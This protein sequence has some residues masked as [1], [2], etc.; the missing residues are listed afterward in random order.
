M[1]LGDF[2]HC[3]FHLGLHL[4]GWEEA[5]ATGSRYVQVLLEPS[6]GLGAQHRRDWGL[7]VNPSEAP[8][9]VGDRQATPA[10]P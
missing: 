7:V 3:N 9:A 10:V 8:D 5:A 6:C 1:T 4:P 2:S